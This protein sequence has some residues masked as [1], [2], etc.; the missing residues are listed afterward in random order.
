[1]Q[2]VEYFAEVFLPRSIWWM[3]FLC[4][5]FCKILWYMRK[6]KKS[7]N[8]LYTQTCNASSFHFNYFIMNKSLTFGMKFSPLLL[9]VVVAQTLLIFPFK[10]VWLKRH[11]DIVTFIRKFTNVILSRMIIK[12]IFKAFPFAIYTM[13][14][15]KNAF[16]VTISHMKFHARLPRVSLHKHTHFAS[17]FKCNVS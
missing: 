11:S 7:H 2:G 15:S 3:E 9:H 1:M 8:F 10:T 14:S 13:L 6:G 17:H 5:H 16:K 4:W 12:L